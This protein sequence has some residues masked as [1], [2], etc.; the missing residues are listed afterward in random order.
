MSRRA[1]PRASPHATRAWWS[2]RPASSGVSPSAGR[3]GRSVSRTSVSA[4][5][6]SAIPTTPKP[7]PSA[8]GKSIVTSAR[9]STCRRAV[10]VSPRRA[11]A[12]ASRISGMSA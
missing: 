8:T 3:G 9:P 10:T 11:R 2:E 1:R 4:A 5:A 12:V 6:S 7:S